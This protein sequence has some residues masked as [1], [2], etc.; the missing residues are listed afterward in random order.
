MLGDWNFVARTGIM[1][2]MKYKDWG[3]DEL[4]ALV[5][6][7]WRNLNPRLS[8]PSSL[9][10]EERGTTTREGKKREAGIEIVQDVVRDERAAWFSSCLYITP[11]KDED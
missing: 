1:R 5:R 10:V 8:L 7:A 4:P 2:L 6:L 3:L 11:R 9:V